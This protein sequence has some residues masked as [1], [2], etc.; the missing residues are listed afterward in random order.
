MKKVLI[1]SYYWPPAGGPGVQRWLKFV[2][3][4]PF[5][6]VTPIMYVPQNAHYPIQDA[7]LV[8]EVPLDLRVIKKSIW[9]PYAFASIFSRRNTNKI[10]SGIIPQE[11]KQGPLQRLMLYIRGNFFIP[12]A[13]KFWVKPSVKFLKQFL[14]EEQ[15]ETIITTGPPHSMHLIGM[16]LK[17]DLGINWIA[18]FRDPWTSIG[19]HEKLKLRPRARRKHQK[20]EKQVLQL[21]DRIIVT[22]TAT[23]EEFKNLTTTPIHIITNGYDSEDVPSHTLD[24]TFTLAHIGSLLS[25]RNPEQ[26]WKALGELVRE[27]A[28]FAY[29]F[30]LKLAGTVGENVL[31]SIRN[32]GLGDYLEIEGYISHKQALARQHQAQMLLLIEIDKPQTKAIIPGKLYEYLVSG[33]PIL[34][35]GPAD[36]DPERIITKTNTGKFFRYQE[37]D[38]MKM[39][40]RTSYQAYK[41][42]SLKSIP[43]GLPKYSRMRL[44]EELANLLQRLS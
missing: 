38:E 19:Y 23:R 4:L 15:I 34:A 12:D 30:R 18:D 32:E 29:D 7:S 20:L 9:E 28:E 31:E 5:F 37:K 1:I 6:E 21:A 42:G 17:R 41:T 14:Q 25:E 43:F 10:S 33:R 13:R 2:K 16:Q 36:S 27:D 26:L 24:A 44:T 3:Y 40:L 35:V 8:R 22:S 11:E 39:Y